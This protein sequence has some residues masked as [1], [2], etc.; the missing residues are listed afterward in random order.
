MNARSRGVPVLIAALGV[1][2][3]GDQPAKQVPPNIVL[4]TLDTTR[5]D[6]LGCYGATGVETPNLDRLAAEGV[7]FATAVTPV[8]QTLPAHCTIMT[9]RTPPGHTVH[10]N[11]SALPEDIQTL[12]EALAASGYETAAFIGSGILAPSSGLRQGFSAYDREFGG[13]PGVSRDRRGDEVVA[14]LESWLPRRDVSRPLFVWIHLYDPHA[15]YDAPEPFGSR[16]AT[17]PY[18]G[19]LA[20]TDSC[21]GRALAALEKGGVL[22]HGLVAVAGDHGEGL[23]DHGEATHSVFIYE[24]TLRVP[25]ILWW[26][27][28]WKP[29]VVVGTARLQDIAPTLLQAAGLP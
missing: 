10:V 21:V 22:A 24:A 26:P 15:P 11:G 12:A 3:C 27:A 19:E 20:F 4:V 5:A 8:P 17:H 2:A 16:F 18:D 13:G 9:G 29:A 6:H 25:L 23:G 7:R 28:R 1:S 14:A